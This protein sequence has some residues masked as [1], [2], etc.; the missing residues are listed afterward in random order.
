[1]INTIQSMDCKEAY[2][3]RASENIIYKNEEVNYRNLIKP[4]KIN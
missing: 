2:A 1:M 4:Y 3:F